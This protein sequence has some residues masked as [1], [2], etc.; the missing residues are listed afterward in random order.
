MKDDQ[1]KCVCS[2]NCKKAKKLNHSKKLKADRQ[3]KRPLHLKNLN[4]NANVNVT[5]DD[6]DGAAV[7]RSAQKNQTKTHKNMNQRNNNLG[8][9]QNR[10]HK[11]QQQQDGNLQHPTTATTIKKKKKHMNESSA[12]MVADDTRQQRLQQR[13]RVV[14]AGSSP[15]GG[16]VVEDNESRQHHRLNVRQFDNHGVRHKNKKLGNHSRNVVASK[17]RHINLMYHED[18]ED[19]LRRV[20][21][22]NDTEAV[23]Q[24]T[25]KRI[26]GGDLMN[27][28]IAVSE[29]NFINDNSILVSNGSI[30]LVL[31]VYRSLLF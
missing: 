22:L 5:N 1:P 15:P 31:S 6:D 9:R 10:R 14:V 18:D 8:V 25:E 19:N 21:N 3:N 4:K 29:N 12:M 11:Q 2:P 26:R 30:Q 7:D 23:L 17:R 16:A 24:I 27:N 20:M 28:F 13:Q